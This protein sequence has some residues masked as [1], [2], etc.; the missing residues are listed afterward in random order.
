MLLGA[1]R[2][3][4]KVARSIETVRPVTLTGK[5][6]RFIMVVNLLSSQGGNV[7][8]SEELALRICDNG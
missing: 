3:G 6:I 8:W 4:D 7:L 5:F 1:R 2:A